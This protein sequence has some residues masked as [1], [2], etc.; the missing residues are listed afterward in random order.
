MSRRTVFH[1]LA[2]RELLDAVAYFE[3]A[4][5]GLGGRFLRALAATCDR[6][7]MTPAIG[8]FPYSVVYSFDDAR[9]RV[10]AIANHRRRPLYWCDRR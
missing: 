4:R 6:I 5:E 8:R 2:E 3:H 9:L 7:A 1:E 10:L